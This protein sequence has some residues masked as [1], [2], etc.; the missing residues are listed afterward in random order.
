MIHIL[1][2]QSGN[3]WILVWPV[4][5]LDFNCESSMALSIIDL[6]SEH[7]AIVNLWVLSRSSTFLLNEE[8]SL[9]EVYLRLR[10]Q[11]VHEV[12]L[13]VMQRHEP[14]TLGTSSCTVVFPA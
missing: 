10:Y 12:G 3:L 6:A 4:Q 11:A 1:G 8:L 5:A 7:I 13:F 2:I 14:Q 9:C